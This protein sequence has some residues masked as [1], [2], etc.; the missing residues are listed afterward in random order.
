MSDELMAVDVDGTYRWIENSYPA[1]KEAFGGATM[2]VVTIADDVALF[3]DDNGLANALQ[4]NWAASIFAHQV[5]FGPVVLCGGADEEG[6]TR[7]ASPEMARVLEIFALSA[8][9]LY[10]SAERV[11]QSITIHADPATVPPPQII[12]ISGP[13]ELMRLLGMEVTGE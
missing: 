9:A 12:A 4:L 5:L 7:P 1:I 6:N 2:D 11:G 8:V 3:V 13:E 10:R